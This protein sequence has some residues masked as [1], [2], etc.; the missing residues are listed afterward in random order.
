MT[1]Q[2]SPHPTNPGPIATELARRILDAIASLRYGTV[3]VV[4]H[5]GQVVQIDRKERIRVERPRK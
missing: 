5:D 4:V 1:Q 3:E 2:D